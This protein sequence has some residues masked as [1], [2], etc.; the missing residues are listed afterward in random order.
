M[1]PPL[2][3]AERVWPMPSTSTAWVRRGS[4][5]V[6]GAGRR[7]AIRHATLLVPMSIAATV[8]VRFGAT[9]FIF[10]VMP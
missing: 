6:V 2:M 10:G 5:S 3:P 4:T 1:L 7:R 9:G 8:T